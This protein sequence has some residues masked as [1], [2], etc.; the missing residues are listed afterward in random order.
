MCSPEGFA[1][2]REVEFRQRVMQKFVKVIDKNFQ[3]SLQK[4]SGLTMRIRVCFQYLSGE[5]I[6][7]FYQFFH[8]LRV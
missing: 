7:V 4:P 3:L 8:V 5:P 1:G 2:E 6:A